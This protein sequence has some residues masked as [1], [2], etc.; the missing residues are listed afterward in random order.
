MDILLL[1]NVVLFSYIS[2][3]MLQRISP[4]PT[5]KKVFAPMYPTKFHKFEPE[6]QMVSFRC[7]MLVLWSE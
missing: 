3:I 5:K 6:I 7:N 1:T 4:I 2:C